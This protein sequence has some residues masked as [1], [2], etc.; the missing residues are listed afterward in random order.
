MPTTSDAAMRGAGGERQLLT[1][2]EFLGPNLGIHFRQ[3]G[4][5]QLRLDRL[6]VSRDP[7]GQHARI[8]RAVFGFQFQAM[9]RQGNQLGVRPAGVQPLR[10]SRSSLPRVASRKTCVPS[11]PT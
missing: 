5:A 4:F 11:S 10:S 2:T 3:F 1:P 8:A 9:L 7:F 6:Q